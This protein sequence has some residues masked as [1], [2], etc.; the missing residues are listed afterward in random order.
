M[1]NPKQTDRQTAMYSY[2]SQWKESGQ[3]QK[4]FCLE[5]KISSS[6]FFYWYK[7]YRKQSS[8]VS[9]FIPIRVH[10]GSE[11]QYDVMEIIYPNGVRLQLSAA[12]HPSI[13]GEL[14]RM[15]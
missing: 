3:S 5:N 2:I 11:K 8:P 12:A 13:I 1:E 7:K 6:N 15:F 4:R 9:G 14:I 10:K